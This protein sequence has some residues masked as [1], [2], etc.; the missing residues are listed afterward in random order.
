MA[1][2]QQRGEQGLQADLR[3]YSQPS[4]HIPSSAS[5]ASMSTSAKSSASTA[6]ART[7][8]FAMYPSRNWLE[9]ASRAILSRRSG[10]RRAKSTSPR[11]VWM[12]VPGLPTRRVTRPCTLRRRYS[13]PTANRSGFC[14]SMSTCG[15]RWTA[16]GH[17]RST[18]ERST[19][20]TDAANI[21]FA[22]ILPGNSARNPASPPTGGPTCR[23]WHRRS[24][25]RRLSRA[26][27]RIEPD[28]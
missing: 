2:P 15:R 11:L 25:R 7:V 16:S 5:S 22:L 26:S 20:S 9:R 21:S 13:R 4:L 14:S 18:V 12:S 27:S 17:R 23:I 6:R 10:C 19:S 8:R 1:S 3:A 28:G 24:E